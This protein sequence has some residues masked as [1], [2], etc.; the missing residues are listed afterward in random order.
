MSIRVLN[1]ADLAEVLTTRDVVRTIEQS[2]RARSEGSFVSP[3]RFHVPAEN[4]SLAITSGGETK[5]ACVV[6]FF[7]SFWGSKDMPGPP[8]EIRQVAGVFDSESGALKGVIV[9]GGVMSLRTGAM[10]AVAIKY[11]SRPDSRRLGILGSGIQARF[12]IDA[13]AVVRQF[14]LVKVY[15]PSQSHR[16]AFA[17]EMRP[18][19]DLDI[20]P[21]ASA[22]EAVR[23]SDVL[24]CCTSSNSPVFE[25]GWLKPGAHV[26]TI[27]PK[28]TSGYEL[29]MEAAEKS[30]VIATDSFA[31]VDGHYSQYGRYFLADT[32]HRAR[33][34]E[35][36]DIVAGTAPGR[37]SPNQMTLFCSVGL[38]GTEIVLASEALRLAEARGVGG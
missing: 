31:Q 14:E 11:L 37:A 8:P 18:K 7:A 9:G 20:R 22:E 36:G 4:G 30:D 2:L 13:A 23:D 16:E 25:V 26:T 38:G 24:I 33:M 21:V 10:G 15:S 1:D 6:G 12:A 29:P 17:E 34:V 32:P 27:G 35:L 3:P 28:Y 5:G 19:V